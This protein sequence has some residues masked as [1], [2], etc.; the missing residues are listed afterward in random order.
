MHVPVVDFAH[1]AVTGVVAGREGEDTPHAPITF[2][3]REKSTSMTSQDT[4]NF[5]KLRL[6]CEVGRDVAQKSGV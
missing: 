4:V 1:S 6:S 2:V 5:L 3:Q